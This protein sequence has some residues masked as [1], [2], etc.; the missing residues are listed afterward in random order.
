[1]VLTW[2]PGVPL[3]V[4]IGVALTV[5]VAAPP[6]LRASTFANGPASTAVS[7]IGV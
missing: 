7:V 2:L 5:L 3:V 6:P 1:M 4:E